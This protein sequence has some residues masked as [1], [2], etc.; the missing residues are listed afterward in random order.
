MSSIWGGG[1][2]PARANG[3]RETI[4]HLKKQERFGETWMFVLWLWEPKSHAKH[5][6]KQN[7]Q[8]E[9]KPWLLRFQIKTWQRKAKT[10]SVWKSDHYKIKENEKKFLKQL[11]GQRKEWVAEW[12]IVTKHSAWNTGIADKGAWGLWTTNEWNWNMITCFYI[13]NQY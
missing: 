4:I 2:Q 3:H 7:S 9:H 10:D 1:S 13:Q 5:D 6:W 12:D 11:T 8:R